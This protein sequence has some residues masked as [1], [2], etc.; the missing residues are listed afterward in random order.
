MGMTFLNVSM[1]VL[2]MTIDHVRYKEWNTTGILKSPFGRVEFLPQRSNT[3]LKL[4]WVNYLRTLL[5][6][7]QPLKRPTLS[8]TQ[9]LGGRSV[10]RFWGI[11]PEGGVSLSLVL[12]VIVTVAGAGVLLQQTLHHSLPVND[13]PLYRLVKNGITSTTRSLYPTYRK[14]V[15]LSVNG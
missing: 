1:F 13:A 14:L 3:M 7:N 9:K 5:R 15:P 4:G 12:L 11:F 6:S 10:V 2:D 8:T